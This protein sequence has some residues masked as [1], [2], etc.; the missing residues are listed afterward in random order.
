MFSWTEFFIGTLFIN[1]V[2]VTIGRYLV[3]KEIIKRW[4]SRNENKKLEDLAE[5]RL[6]QQTLHT[7]RDHSDNLKT[8]ALL[9]EVVRNTK[10]G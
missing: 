1:V 2:V 4:F 6:E 10:K 9:E 3:D 5:Q 7:T 8:H